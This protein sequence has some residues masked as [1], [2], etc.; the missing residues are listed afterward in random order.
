MEVAEPK[1]QI[2]TTLV[3]D[4]CRTIGKE[5]AVNLEL[6]NRNEVRPEEKLRLFEMGGANLGTSMKIGGILGNGSQ[7]EI[8]CLGNYGRC[9]GTILALEKDLKVSVNMTLD[10]SHKVNT[11]ALPY[12]LLWAKARSE[13]TE[14]S[15]QH[16][17]KEKDRV[18]QRVDSSPNIR[19]DGDKARIKRRQTLLEQLVLLFYSPYEPGVRQGY[20]V[21]PS[22][23][24]RQLRLFLPEV[25]VV[26][27]TAS[28]IL[29]YEIPEGT[30]F[31]LSRY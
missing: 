10:L 21:Q 14:R 16:L 12:A 19:I 29:I 6:R 17:A 3:W 30:S 7:D 20:I 11:N 13:K 31:S 1:R 2:I 4:Y 24:K 18:Q 25:P 22:V 5:E 27:E 9:L 23:M 15:I 28:P 26:F 8:R